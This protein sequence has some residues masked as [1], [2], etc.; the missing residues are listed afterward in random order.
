MGMQ[1]RLA[2]PPSLAGIDIRPDS[3]DVTIADLQ[4]S[5]VSGILRTVLRPVFVGKVHNERQ[6]LF[7]MQ[8]YGVTYGVADC[9]P[10]ATLAK[11]LQETC[12]REGIELWRAQYN[13]VP[14]AIKVGRNESERLL[15][16]ERTM[17][18]DVVH[19]AFQ[20]G[21]GM[22][23]PQNY[24]ELNSGAFATELK[25]P[26]KVMTEWHKRP[27][28]DWKNNGADHAFHSLNL[29]W[30]A[31][32][33]ISPY[34]IYGLGDQTAIIRGSVQGL[35]PALVQEPSEDGSPPKEYDPIEHIRSMMKGDGEGSE[36]WVS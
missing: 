20:T 35:M 10:E 32:L 34:A 33:E 16:L 24:K 12:N 27:W 19:N 36:I 31:Y 21:L 5:A 7:V 29:L 22:Q 8:Q 6:A 9:R 26:T 13:T 3:W 15:N 30:V 4:R 17:T 28:W 1:P 2:S 11:R 23:L 14:S 18:L 25:N